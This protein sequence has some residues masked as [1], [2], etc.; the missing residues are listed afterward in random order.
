VQNH[1][2]H[3][4]KPRWGPL[5]GEKPIVVICPKTLLWQWQ[6]EMRELLGMPSAVWDGRHWVDEHGLEYPASGIESIRKCPRKVGI[7]SSGLVTRRSEAIGHLL[8]MEYDCVI[9]DEAHRARRRNL[10]EN[11]DAE[12]PDPNNLLR[13]MHDIA[14]RTRSLLLATATP[15]QLRP[16]EAW[17]LLNVLSQGDESVLGNMWSKWRNAKEGLDLIMSRRPV[18]EHPQEQWDWIR[19]P[20]PPKSEHRDFEVLRGRLGVADSAVVVPGHD[21]ERLSAPDRARIKNMFPRFTREHYPFI[22]RIIRRT[23]EQLENQIDPETKEPLLQRVGVRLWGEG[24][25]DAIR[26]P[27]YLKEAYE[28]AEQICDKLGKRMKG[29]GFLKTLLL[30]RVGSSIYAGL[31]TAEQMLENWE[32]VEV[33]VVEDV[34]EEEEEDVASDAEPAQVRT[35]MSKSLTPEERN[36]LARFVDALEANQERDPKYAVVRQCLFERDWLRLG[37]IIFSQ[38]RDSIGWLAEQLTEEIPEEP[39]ALYSGPATSGIMLGGEWQR[40]S[41]DELKTLVRTGELRLLLGTD[42]ASEGLNLQRLARLINLDLPWNPTRLEQRKGRI[43]RIGQVHAT[44][45][46]YNMRYRDSV[47]D[48]V[49]ELLSDRL[50]D[51]FSLFG[52]VPDVLEDVWVAIALGDKEAAQRIIDEVPKSHPFEL[53]YTQVEKIDW[54]TCTKVLD[55]AEMQRVLAQGW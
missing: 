3:R 32:D 24:E 14:A 35:A 9:L 38:Y 19:N 16:I 5:T 2:L 31:R 39:I 7:V 26:L 21:F 4:A 18:T 41:R 36:L 47:E 52:Q 33:A 22:R 28:L 27:P 25:S 17:D 34:E 50:Q 44:V 1:S 40:K 42:A 30:R 53:R 6:G 51:I 45:E 11:R 8:K 12:R 29:A 15:V 20:L 43:Q 23:R 10:G 54:E 37:C 13:F 49:H 55:A 46:I 48:R